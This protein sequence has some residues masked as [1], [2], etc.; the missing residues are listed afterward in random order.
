MAAFSN[1]FGLK[2]VFEKLRFCDGLVWTVGLTVEIK[3]AFSNSSG[4]KSVFEKL[5]FCDGLVWT[6]GLTVEIKLAFSNSSG[7]KSVF[8]K[9]RFCDGLVWTVGLTSVEIK[10]RFQFLRCSVRLDFLPFWESG[11]LSSTV[12]W[13]KERGI[14]K[15][16]GIEPSI[17]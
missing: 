12:V 17:V 9:L 6:A 15:R 10:L 4:L 5:R 14:A 11:C 7:L 16:V 3:L 2:S 8:E 1:S 13:S